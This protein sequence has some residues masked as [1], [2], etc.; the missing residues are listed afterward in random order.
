MKSTAI[1]LALAGIV[2]A[3]APSQARTWNPQGVTLAQDYSVI[4]D[5]RPN[6][7]I[8]ML[9]WLSSPLVQ[10]SPTAQALLDKYIILGV[11]HGKQDVGGKVDFDSQ[12]SLTAKDSQGS[13]LKSISGDQ[14]PPTVQA[15]VVAFGGV[16]KQSLGAMGQGMQFFVF[17]AGDNL[18]ACGSKGRL[19][20]SFAGTDYTYDTP[21]PGCPAP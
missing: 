18:R 6:K 3:G 16:M 21:I 11:V 13:A 9:M 10:N 4:V 12:L 17:E 2:L 7:E 19:T 15:A 5:N 1:L 14:V 8:V 20:A